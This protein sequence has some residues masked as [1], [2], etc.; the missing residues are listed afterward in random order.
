MKLKIEQEGIALL[1]RKNYDI[2]DVIQIF[3]ELDFNLETSSDRL[4]LVSNIC[5][6]NDLTSLMSDREDGGLT[7][8]N[9]STKDVV[10][11]QTNIADKLCK[12]ADYL[13]MAYDK[14]LDL[15][16]EELVGYT[17]FNT[18]K[19]DENNGRN[20]SSDGLDDVLDDS[21]DN[22]GNAK[23]KSDAVHMLPEDINKHS[24]LNSLYLERLYTECEKRYYESIDKYVKKFDSYVY[25]KIGLASKFD[26][27]ATI[28][29]NGVTIPSKDYYIYLM[30]EL[31]QNYPP[32]LSYSER[33]YKLN[34]I[35]EKSKLLSRDYRDA[36]LGLLKII[37]FNSVSRGD[38]HRSYDEI[39]L[40]NY[41]VVKELLRINNNS[42]SHDLGLEVD[43]INM[44]LGNKR[45]YKCFNRDL[46]TLVLTPREKLTLDMYRHG[47]ATQQDIANE[48]LE[49]YGIV[50]TVQQISRDINSICKKISKAYEKDV[51]DWLHIEYRRGIYKKCT[52][53][54]EV[55]L[56]SEFNKQR[57]GK[58]GVE[59]VC[60]SCKSSV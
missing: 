3:S 52:K 43:Y 56:I 21:L 57:T 31:I 36:K 38:N 27:I 24:L 46:K 51:W 47:E 49:Q 5:S 34:K 59:S 45:Q 58:Y 13:L 41:K 40:T 20:L 42:L 15:D 18:G 11:S 29:I 16:N 10:Y 23:Y 35:V 8:S 14:E 28:S 50:T 33:N 22:N 37:G 6:E 1:P 4:E 48:L 2:S 25:E 32:K 12:V 7:K 39:D 17:H 54:G 26:G 55:K 30:T 9:P 44:L 19:E 60:K 53:C